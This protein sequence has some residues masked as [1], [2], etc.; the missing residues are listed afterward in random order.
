M[1]ASRLVAVLGALSVR[2][3]YYGM[4]AELYAMAAVQGLGISGHLGASGRVSPAA[5]HWTAIGLNA[6]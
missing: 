3:F 2:R 1:V 6:G 5:V 4:S